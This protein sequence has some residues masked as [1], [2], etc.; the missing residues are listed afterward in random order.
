M[1]ASFDANR[2][3]A[4]LQAVLLSAGRLVSYSIFAETDREYGWQV[5]N[6]ARAFALSLHPSL[7]K[8]WMHDI[9]GT[10]YTP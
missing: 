4:F 6:W 5:D 1:A 10:V 3:R 7:P 2:V 8:P 9:A